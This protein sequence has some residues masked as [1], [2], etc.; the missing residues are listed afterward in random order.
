MKGTNTNHLNR[1]RN[2]IFR[3]YNERIL[4]GARSSLYYLSLTVF[5]EI[6]SSLFSSIFQDQSP[7]V[8]GANK[9]TSIFLLRKSFRPPC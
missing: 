1:V 3:G 5:V 9:K 8:L 6:F 7:A 2:L 4:L